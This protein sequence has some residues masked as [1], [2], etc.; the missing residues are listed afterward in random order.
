MNDAAK[1]SG[2]SGKTGTPAKTG[3]SATPTLAERQQR[4]R[5]AIDAR[6]DSLTAAADGDLARAERAAA[7]TIVLGSAT[8]PLSI[9]I[10]LVFV[11]LFLPHSGEVRGFDVLLFT[12]RASEYL[13]TMPERVY[14]WFAFV[15]G[16]L[17]AVA[18][19]V[20]RSTLVAWVNWVVC[21]IGAY[22]CVLAVGMRNTRG[23]DEPGA[24]PSIGLYLGGIGLIIIVIALSTRIFRRTAV[25]AAMNARRREAADRDEESQS[26]QQRLRVGQPPVTNVVVDDDRRRKAA[27]RRR[28]KLDHQRDTE[29]AGPDRDPAQPDA[30]GEA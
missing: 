19:M 6:V 21:G 20:S 15:G 16:V 24:G 3:T 14:A 29:A 1:K 9:G 18:T 2:K 22:Y 13:T 27:A 26:A 8:V 7:G 11:S 10:L 30:P 17:L 25:Q 4:R 23:P 5:E 12:D 28:A